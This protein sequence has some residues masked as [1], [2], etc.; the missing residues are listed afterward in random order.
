MSWHVMTCLVHWCCQGTSFCDS[1]VLGDSPRVGLWGGVAVTDQPLAA[2]DVGYNFWQLRS[3]ALG[4]CRHSSLE[5]NSASG[6]LLD[7]GS[8]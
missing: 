4:V 8:Q 6:L 5:Y 2:A 1:A 7:C 3:L